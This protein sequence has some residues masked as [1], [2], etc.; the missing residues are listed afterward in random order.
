M[1]G[2]QRR[3]GRIPENGQLGERGDRLLEE[4]HVLGAHLGEHPG[5]ARHVAAGLSEARHDSARDGI[6]HRHED[7][8]NRL[9]G[10][11]GR[12]RGLGR[13]RDDNVGLK[14]NKL[15]RQFGKLIEL[16]FRPTELERDVLALEVTEIRQALTH[17]RECRRRIWP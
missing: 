1:N 5:G 9:R 11:L 10:L 8:R 6:A 16:S 15:G 2:L 12:Q 14:A 13:E 7:N 4:L 3:V 17:G